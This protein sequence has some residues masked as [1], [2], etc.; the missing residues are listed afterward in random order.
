MM[1]R[2][3]VKMKSKYSTDCLKRVLLES[4]WEIVEGGNSF[5]DLGSV[6][7][8]WAD[9]SSLQSTWEYLLSDTEGG[10]A[11]SSKD[12][13]VSAIY[14]KC[15]LV[16]KA[17]MHFWF[18][19]YQKRCGEARTVLQNVP[20]AKILE[21]E[22]EE[23]P[24]FGFRSTHRH[25][26]GPI[27]TDSPSACPQDIEASIEEVRSMLAEKGGRWILKASTGNAGE[28]LVV[29]DDVETVGGLLR[30]R[31]VGHIW[32]VQK[33]I[34]NPLL[35]RGRK[36]HLR[37]HVLAMNA[38]EVHLHSDV[39]ALLSTVPYESAAMSD[40]WAHLTNHCVQV[41][42]PEYDESTSIV[43]LEELTRVLEEGGLVPE[44]AEARVAQLKVDLKSLTKA[45]F[46]AIQKAP[47]VAWFPFD[48][49]FEV[50]GVDMMLDTDW[51]LWLLEVNAG[52]DFETFGAQNTDR[53][54]A[55]LRD[56]LRLAVDPY[57]AG[58]DKDTNES[59]YELCYEHKAEGDS[60][61]TFK[62]VMRT[63]S[64]GFQKKQ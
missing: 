22:E 31:G 21:V 40:S 54:E 19:R 6:A 55:F 60:V 23:V 57:L 34:E 56:T 11:S 24:F 29:F 43:L 28:D 42:H 50:F 5:T 36:F 49:C 62:R 8:H 48:N 52:P 27:V 47:P 46:E 53:C 58:A 51:K 15:G 45:I 37:V 33:Y 63:L 41:E 30:T 64:N 44:E 25:T 3:A 7:L 17:D 61:E 59:G 20:E 16:R 9:F 12:L 2:A 4:G 14:V 32:V 1:K 26:A 38:V 39:I 10:E 13:R 35:L 18:E